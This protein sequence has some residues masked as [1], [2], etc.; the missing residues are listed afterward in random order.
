MRQARIALHHGRGRRGSPWANRPT[1][2]YHLTNMEVLRA[3]RRPAPLGL[4]VIA[5]AS[6]VATALCIAFLDQPVARWV[7]QW[8]PHPVWDRGIA[9]LEW[10]IGL[11]IWKLLSA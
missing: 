8:E 9:V 10:A 5:A 4:L 1:Y 2:G 6:E 7:A 11:P 3:E